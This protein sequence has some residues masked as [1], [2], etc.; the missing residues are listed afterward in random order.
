MLHKAQIEFRGEKEHC[1]GL[2]HYFN[3]NDVNNFIVS[4]NNQHGYMDSEIFSKDNTL[5]RVLIVCDDEDPVII[6]DYWEDEYFEQLM[7]VLTQY[8]IKTNCKNGI[9]P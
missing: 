1:L 5:W 7:E 9:L 6:G 4:T 2:K 8:D 3:D